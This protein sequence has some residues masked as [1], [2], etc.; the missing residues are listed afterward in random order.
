MEKPEEYSNR[1]FLFEHP[2]I[3]Q[4]VILRH[5]LEMVMEEVVDVLTEKVQIS[6]SKDASVGF[7]VD[8]ELYEQHEKKVEWLEMT[9]L[10]LRAH[11]PRELQK[12]ISDADIPLRHRCRT[13]A[14]VQVHAHLRK[15]LNLVQMRLVE[16]LLRH[17]LQQTSHLPHR[18]LCQHLPSLPFLQSLRRERGF[19][20]GFRG[21]GGLTSFFDLWF[22]WRSSSLIVLR[23]RFGN[24]SR[25]L[26][27]SSD[28]FPSCFCLM[29]VKSAA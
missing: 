10:Y 15:Y 26:N 13:T 17:P 2:Q 8:D 29:C 14:G 25:G 28:T 6:L 3:L 5:I 1:I 11:R 24:F 23:W 7:R 16:L 18:S 22:E 20:Y 19:L 9:P 4:L 21:R 27:E 12:T